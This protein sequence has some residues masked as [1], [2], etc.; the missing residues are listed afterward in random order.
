MIMEFIEAIKKAGVVGAGGAGF[1]TY[2]KLNAKAEYLIINAA[3][4]EPLIETDKYL[5]R[6]F[7]VR[8]V[9]T[10]EKMAAH[11]EAT[12]KI[13]A[14]KAEYVREIA[15]LESAIKE[16]ESDVALF[17]MNAYYPAGD[18][19]V[20]V[21][22]ITGRIVPER[23]LP[24]NVGCV[25]DNV[26]T[27]L[28][29]ADALEDV[30]VSQKYLSVTGAV[31]K[32]K[33]TR[34]P[35]GTPVKAVLKA[36]GVDYEDKAVILGGPMMGKMLAKKEQIEAAV[37]TK[38]TGNLLVLPKDHYLV[39]KSQLSI[40][41]MIRQASTACLQCRFC[42]DLCPRE[43]IGH[44]VKPHLTMRTI[45]RRD[46]ITDNEEFER[47]FGH[48]ANCSSCG[49]CDMFSCPMGLS[50]RKINDYVKTLLREKGINPAKNQAPV[51]KSYVDDRRIPT[52]RLIARLGLSEYH[53]HALPEFF[54]M[55][56]EE[57]IVPVSQ[58]IGKP[59]AA[60]VKVGDTVKAG[61]LIAEAA[62]G[63]SVNIHTGFAGT[64]KEIGPQGIRI[65]K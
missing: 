16:L 60:C 29:I 50:P 30:P 51:A 53:T 43:A 3:E 4:C 64:V 61:D 10:V 54:E 11:L 37:V 17:K 58:H 12:H 56:T 36:A 48:A 14:L 25:V 39:K 62:E 33:M 22:N 31:S 18:E 40:E 8:I 5:M 21:Q 46:Q 52:E 57:V 45:W 41:R 55:E 23:G 24:L 34:V 35:L 49:A 7:A 65:A 1:P 15:A 47:V 20:L 38:T 9:E 42:T 28:S 59:A 6:E 32:A 2:V 19:Q 13:I 63:L 27:V 44:D 26:G